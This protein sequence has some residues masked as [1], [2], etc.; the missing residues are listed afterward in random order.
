MDRKRTESTSEPARDGLEPEVLP[1]SRNGWV[2]NNERL[3]VLLYRTV[4]PVVGTDPASQFEST[5]LRNG[6]PPQ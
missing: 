6:W 3:P 1:L 4:I 2:P 5:F